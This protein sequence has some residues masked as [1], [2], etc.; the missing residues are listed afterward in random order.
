MKSGG[1]VPSLHDGMAAFAAPN[2]GT[3]LVRNHELNTDDVE[4]DGA[5]P[6]PH[7]AGGTYDPDA[8]AGG[9]STLLVGPDRR[10]VKDWV[11]LAG[12]LTNCA[13]G[14]TP[15]GTWLTCE[16][17]F[18]TLAKPHG[19][20][21]EV[22]PARGGNPV[23]IVGMGRY[24]HEAVAFD[25]Q[26][27]AYL[28]EDADSPFG[29]IY[30]YLPTRPFGG[31]G[32][33]HAGGSLQ[34]LVVPGLGN[35]LSIVQNVGMVLNAQWVDVPNPNPGDSDTPVREQ[36]HPLGAT[37][38]QKAEGIW[39]GKD[40]A[41]WFVSSYGGGPE[42]EDEE[43]RSAAAH[44]GQVWK[45]DPGHADARARRAVP[46]RHA[47]RRPRQHHGWAARLRRRLHRRRGRSMARRHHRRRPRV[48]VRVQRQQRF[49]VRRR[50]VLARR[51]HAVR[52]SAG[53]GLDVRD[54]G[55]VERRAGRLELRLSADAPEKGR[56]RRARPGPRGSRCT[57]Q[58][59]G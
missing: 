17:E 23:P 44:S 26:G 11:S 6:V 53:P 28:T 31:R 39:T 40:G 5:T 57:Q 45:Y 16:E 48:S 41:I 18:D 12:T 56:D 30:R 36:V 19:Y 1:V 51:P 14:P 37:A 3:V 8:K 55:A 27:I 52:Q 9:T 49:R 24:E 32:S 22:D 4:E 47:V 46:R 13:G 42:A 54:L 15:W 10:L 20:V 59:H 43:D 34:A 35:D 38:I 2:G 7:I 50:H 33:L 25:R 21:F 29:C 58:E